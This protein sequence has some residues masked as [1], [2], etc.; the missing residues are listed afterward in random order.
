MS[1]PSLPSA[2]PQLDSDPA[3]QAPDLFRGCRF[4]IWRSVEAWLDLEEYEA[5]ALEGAEDFDL[6][7][8][9]RATATQVKD[10]SHNLTL[11]SQEVVEAIENFWDVRKRNPEVRLRYRFLTTAKAGVEKGS[12]FGNGVPGL[13]VWGK[14]AKDGAGIEHLREFLLNEEKLAASVKEF[15]KSA[16]AEEVRTDLLEPLEWALDQGKAEYVETMV[17]NRLILHGEKQG[18]PAHDAERVAEALYTAASEATSRNSNRILLRSDFLRIFDDKTAKRINPAEALLAAQVHGLIPSMPSGSS[19]SLL[20]YS[21]VSGPPPLPPE[22]AQRKTLVTKLGEALTK[23]GQLVL[24]GSTG[25]GK[26]TLGKLLSTSS[27]LWANLR[28]EKAVN[29]SVLQMLMVLLSSR[30]K[31]EGVVF[32]DYTPEEIDENLFGG[33]VYSLQAQGIPFIVT[34]SKAL[35]SRLATTLG[36][37]EAS[38]VQV[39]TFSDEETSEILLASGCPEK[40]ASSLAPLLNAL[41]SGHPQLIHARIR[42]LQASNWQKRLEELL[43]T[44]KSE[45]EIR[46]EARNL[47]QRMPEGARVL[48]YRLSVVAQSFR[49][50]QALAIASLPP[51]VS[52]A[53]EAFDILSGPWIERVTDQYFRVSPLLNKAADDIW[54]ATEVRQLHRSLATVLWETKPLTPNE[55]AISFFHALLGEDEIGMLR[56]AFSLLS[57]KEIVQK[58]T[59]PRLQ[60]FSYVGLDPDTDMPSFIGLGSRSFLRMLQYKM[61]SDQEHKARIA[62]AW[63]RESTALP[64]PRRPLSRYLLHATLLLDYGTRYPIPQLIVWLHECL[65]MLPELRQYEIGLESLQLGPALTDVMADPAAGL[66]LFVLA[67]CSDV[68]S[69]LE[70]VTSLESQ[71]EGF[72]VRFLHIFDLVPGLASGLIDRC[73]L[74]EKD[75]PQPDWERCLA[76]LDRIRRNAEHWTREDLR[77]AAVR[78]K[79]TIIHEYRGGTE[80]ALDL[81]REDG[82]CG[83]FLAD[84]EATLLQDQGDHAAAWAIWHAGLP[85]WAA[86]NELDE[87]TLA[88]AYKKA[89]I[90]AGHLG[91]W[92]ESARLFLK[93]STLLED[94]QARHKK[95]DSPASSLELNPIRLLADH[96]LGLWRAGDCKESIAAFEAVLSKM[97]AVAPRLEDFDEYKVFLKVLG[98]ILAWLDER[99][100]IEPPYPGMAST[101][102]VLSEILEL[103]QVSLEH[104]WA[105]LGAAELRAGSSEVFRRSRPMLVAPDLNPVTRYIFRETELSHKLLEGDFDGLV[106]VIVALYQAMRSNEAEPTESTTH[107]NRLLW[108]LYS[109][110]LAFCWHDPEGVPPWSKWRADLEEAVPDTPE[111]IES[112]FRSAEA[113]FELDIAELTSSLL[114][115]LN[116]DPWVPL[117][118]V[119]IAVNRSSRP[120]VIFAAQAVLVPLF[121]QAIPGEALG[122]ILSEVVE[123]QWRRLA[124]SPAL[125]FGPRLTVPEIQAACES[126]PPGLAKAAAILLAAEPAVQVRLDPD[127]RQVL[128]T[129]RDATPLITAR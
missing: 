10:L 126:Q 70:L 107:A 67:R 123:S 30:P 29:R 31:P 20:A 75:L 112:W 49:R 25:M 73:W 52:L 13:E 93:A 110:L 61:A 103:P 18:I 2:L 83:P 91:E 119:R 116:D 8:S 104:L 37:P 63:D 32:D 6:L 108:I 5:L 85:D 106:P 76:V 89:A 118:A 33:L 117:Y 47:L 41:T 60:W 4:Q 59:F 72:R 79:V 80:A 121:R 105:M 54:D 35:P 120:E 102:K 22:L 124:E 11:R 65:D 9:G 15:L 46:V 51:A 95:Q 26:S 68:D 64:E 114:K 50:D 88:F 111:I 84:Q 42:D 1:T 40:R 71:D 94:Y 128:K 36:L 69:L 27:W 7:A 74:D 82:V 14:A 122:K 101:Q 96:A 53:G 99:P 129:L 44:P 48:A 78:A 16:S 58:L 113:A 92:G 56:V 66:F 87:V 109:N 77:Q 86:H 115:G 23:S 81:L 17:R 38:T 55:A 98:H 45:E 100:G 57:A 127:R 43:R 39:P 21:P 34:T 19:I 28:S 62:S 3:R 12:P 90:S 97:S 125:L 24:A